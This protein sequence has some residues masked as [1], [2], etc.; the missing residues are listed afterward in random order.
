MLHAGFRYDLMGQLLS[1]HPGYYGELIWILMMLEQWL[2]RHSSATGSSSFGRVG[3]D[4]PVGMAA[5]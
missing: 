3:A 5:P 1:A 2:A 4:K